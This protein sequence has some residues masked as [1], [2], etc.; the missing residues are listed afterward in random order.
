MSNVSRIQPNANTRLDQLQNFALNLDD[1]DRV[2]SERTADGL[3]LYAS[4]K[5]T[6]LA[7]LK[8]SLSNFVAFFTQ[9][10]RN[11]DLR[12]AI[13]TVLGRVG[14]RADAAVLSSVK[15]ALDFG[16]RGELKAA[17]LKMLTAAVR[18]EDGMRGPSPSRLSEQT[19][20]GVAET[21]LAGLQSELPDEAGPVFSRQPLFAIDLSRLG[22]D[23]ARDFAKTASPAD[24]DAFVLTGAP[25]MR[26][27]L[28]ASMI[29]ALPSA[30]DPQTQ[31]MIEKTATTILHSA[32]ATLADGRMD[33]AGTITI[34]A[35]RSNSCASSAKAGSGRS[36]SIASAA[37]RKR[38]RSNHPSARA[39][40]TVWKTRIFA[41]R[42]SRR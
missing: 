14:A 41:R 12:E 9:P 24:R 10:N 13:A 22:A 31:D 3:V 15:A 23:L 32:A 27:A 39:K 38:S 42:G 21:A 29:E 11:R 34:G 28:V 18:P 4:P 19:L 1:K 17:S 5:P 33:A 37:E 25:A 20:A 16:L 26:E 36:S 2:R 8:E 40:R 6:G 7:K 35:R 30:P